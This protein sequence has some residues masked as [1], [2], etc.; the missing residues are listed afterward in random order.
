MF[1]LISVSKYRHTYIIP[2]KHVEVYCFITIR[3][4]EKADFSL[5]RIWARRNMSGFQEASVSSVY[6]YSI[7]M[8]VL[9][10]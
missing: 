2:N 5:N 3:N 10:I 7:H 4:L 9:I 1:V 8:Q 6:G